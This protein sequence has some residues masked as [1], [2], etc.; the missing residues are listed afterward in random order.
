MTQAPPL[1]HRLRTGPPRQRHALL[2]APFYPKDP[3]GSFGKHVLTPAHTLTVI[4]AATPEDWTVDFWDENVLQGSPPVDPFPVVVGITVHLTFARR[5]YELAHWYRERGAVVVL[6]GLH[7]T[8]CPDE[9]EEHA[10][11]I[12]IGEGTQAWREVLRDVE[13]GEVRARYTGKFSHAFSEE[14]SPRREVL[15]AGIFLTTASLIATRGCRNRCDFCYMATKGNRMPH[16]LRPVAEVAAEF[17]ATGEPYGVFIDNNLGSRPEYLRD[18]CRAL[19]PLNK[20][21]SAAVTID[22]TDDPSLVHAM[23][24]AGCTGVFVGLETLIGE[25]L[26]E[27][28]KHTPDPSDY[29][30]RVAVFHAH[31]I[32]V[33]GSF[34]LGFDHDGPDVFERTVGWIEENR[35]ECATFHILTPY[36]GTPLFRKLEREGRILH[37]NWDLYDTS[38]AVFQPRSMTP[39][40]LE[41]GYQWCY[42]RLF[43]HRSIWKRRPPMNEGLLS[44]LG[45]SYLYKHTNWLW[46]WLIRHRASRTVWRPLIHMAR[47]TN[48]GT[49]VATAPPS[50]VISDTPSQVISDSDPPSD[51]DPPSA[52]PAPPAPP[53]QVTFQSPPLPSYRRSKPPERSGRGEMV[54]GERRCSRN[55]HRNGAEHAGDR[56]GRSVDLEGAVGDVPDEDVIA[57]GAR[58]EEA[59]GVR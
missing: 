31:G 49:G 9:A 4:A 1:D 10:D 35:L 39:E 13:T 41:Q 11:A 46:P 52:A 38:H 50:Q 21:W 12:V 34:V 17:E 16:Q 19:R 53:S 43:G 5:A 27:A 47:L 22:L 45:M 48:R 25:N 55:V 37:R 8:A 7:V 32:Q 28:H 42:Q 3:N 15:P 59:A 2:I 56:L 14:P 30:R 33:N 6:G 24:D 23:A 58:D 29:A 44:Y 26:R 18:L 20:I 40:Q 57:F 36:P 51:P 54:F